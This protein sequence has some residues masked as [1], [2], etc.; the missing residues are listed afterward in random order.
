MIR[1][2]C[3][4]SRGAQSL[5]IIYSI[6]S[7][8]QKFS[9]KIGKRK[10]SKFC[11]SIRSTNKKQKFWRGGKINNDCLIE[12]NVDDYLIVG[13]WISNSDDYSLILSTK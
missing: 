7:T 6:F 13:Y 8:I 5:L 2:R 3:R 1:R 4:N 9:E 12:Q 10:N 11:T